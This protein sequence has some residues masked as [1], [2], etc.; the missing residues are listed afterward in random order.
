MA[1]TKET[2]DYVNEVMEHLIKK[3]KIAPF[4]PNKK[5][6]D[7][8]LADIVKCSYIK[9]L[10]MVMEI[11]PNEI[12]IYPFDHEGKKEVVRPGFL[13]KQNVNKNTM[14]VLYD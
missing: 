10:F 5:S 9:G 12:L 6:V 14:K 7:F 3:T 13:E 8:K 1:K 4:D 11:H 2:S